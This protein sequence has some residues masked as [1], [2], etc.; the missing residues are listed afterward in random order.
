MTSA[1]VGR[2]A[3]LETAWRAL[4]QS[5][6]VL[7]DGPAGIGKTALWDELCA[8]AE[9]TGWLVLSCAPSEGEAGLALSALADVLH[10]LADLGMDLPEPQRFA[11]ER[12]L[13]SAN[14]DNALDERAL[15]AAVRSL[16]E[17]AAV[18]GRVLLA[19]DDAPWL[20]PPSERALR[21]A[22]R[23]LTGRMSVLVARRT[24]DAGPVAAPL[25]L[26][27]SSVGEVA[28]IHLGPL[29]IGALQ[30]VLRRRL[31][32]G[33]SRPLLARIVREAGGNPLLAIELARAVLR[34]GPLP[35][36]GEDLP[37][38]T[39]MQDLVDDA[40]RGIPE[41]T[42]RGVRL[43]ALLASPGLADLTAAG[44]PPAVFDAAE[45]AGLLR[46]TDARR[47][48]FAHPVY[49]SAVRS[50]IPAGE[51]RRLHRRLAEVVADPDERARQLASCTVGPD[52]D[53]A[54]ELA[55]A[56]ERQRAKGAPELAAVLYGRAIE[57]DA[58]VPRWTLDAARCSFDSGDY[59]S[60]AAKAE[61]IA[62]ANGGD[63]R[64]DALL[65]RAMVHWTVEDSGDNAA[66]TAHEALAT[67]NITN[68]LAG[69]V[70]AY[71]SLYL[72]E[73]A[74]AWCHADTA[75]A[76]LA[77]SDPDRELLA[78]AMMGL[79]LNE[80]RL[81]HQP[82]VDLLEEALALEDGKPSWFAGTVPAV[83]WKAVDDHDRARTRLT[84]CLELAEA[85]GD[86]P[87]Q[88]EL[89]AHLAEAESL[90]GRWSAAER[91]LGAGLEL[92]ELL[93]SSVVG[94][95]L[96]AAAL[97]AFRGNLAAAGRVAEDGLRR[98]AELDDAWY[99]RA[100][101]QLAGLVALSSGRASDA[102]AAYGEV[103]SLV[104]AL[105]MVEP[106]SQRIEPDWI[107]ASVASGDVDTAGAAL[108]RLEVR[109]SRLPRPWTTLGL[110]RGRV[111]LAG[112]TGA[113]PSD[114][115]DAVAEARR[116]VAS[117]VLPLERARCLL[118]AG[119]AQ[120]RIRHKRAA[121]DALTQ[122]I[123]EFDTLGAGV[124]AAQARHELDRVGGR[125]PAPL[126]LS[127]TEERV[128]RLAAAGATNKAIADALFIS[129]KTVEGNLARIFRKLGVSRR[130]QLST[131][132]ADRRSAKGAATQ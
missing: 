79:F 86:E 34:R 40:L 124:F 115:L 50:G 90:A 102:A 54:R 83:W 84:A 51:R 96:L 26:D 69:R 16:L 112:A 24:G 97:D 126:A 4:E 44:V 47:V 18:G 10:P 80:V 108:E 125:P 118:V 70:H 31:G 89:H 46:V 15:G 37:A 119:I 7:I 3:V 131:A 65:L 8:E 25:E 67:T 38:A 60:A 14:T 30:L 1:I 63:V 101:L 41:E 20:D 33:L 100:Y 91:H 12:V 52:A 53:V 61:T 87:W 113:D 132:L 9:R 36:P 11:V 95:R 121:R 128:A 57:L 111:L 27:R 66:K 21:F 49:V 77:D 28:H 17:A 6:P 71:M 74:A 123:A 29:G 88:Q 32:G 114:A 93:G 19:V 82:R 99:R 127:A 68:T 55:A 56:A 35:S 72:D 23:R 92:G 59:E 116:A 122:A 22:I 78:G 107:E 5:R 106:L 120:R 42:R 81:G 103:A 75:C 62:A 43:A 39:S 48:E 117:D 64:A 109:H 98:A 130:T 105:G 76:L 58:D 94:E 13:L 85:R 73:P 110:A 2:D 104:D 45:D 129:P